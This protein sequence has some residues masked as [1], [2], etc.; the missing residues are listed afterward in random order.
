M[1]R[2]TNPIH[3]P[4]H[5]QPVSPQVTPDVL[6]SLLDDAV[7]CGYSGAANNQLLQEGLAVAGSEGGAAVAQLQR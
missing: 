3:H 6:S 7:G 4:Y 1:C 5:H 2:S